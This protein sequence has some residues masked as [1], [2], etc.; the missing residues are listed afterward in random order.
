C[1]DVLAGTYSER[2][3]QDA[4]DRGYRSVVALPLALTDTVTGAMVL[5]AQAPNFFDEEELKLLNELAGDISFAL[6]SIDN[7]KRAHFLSYYDSLTE[8]PNTTLFLDRLEQLMQSA[9]QKNN[10]VFVIALNLNQFKQINDLYGRHIGDEVLKVAAGRLNSELAYSYSVTRIGADNF[11]LMGEQAEH[12]DVSD[13]CKDIVSLLSL[14]INIQRQD[15]E[16]SVRMG[17]SL[18]P[19]DAKDGESLLKNAEMA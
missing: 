9:L 18:F 2:T 8:L 11:A 10:S 13:C 12:A 14:P 6:R 7:K 5:Y 17:V 1:N 15:L 3:F 16:V 19:P 4:R